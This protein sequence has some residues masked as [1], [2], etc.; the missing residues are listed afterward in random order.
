MDW[1]SVIWMWIAV[2]KVWKVLN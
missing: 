1:I 2:D